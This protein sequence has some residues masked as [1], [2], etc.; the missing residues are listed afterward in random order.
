MK[1]ARKEASTKRNA[2]II[3][4]WPKAPNKPK[5]TNVNISDESIGVHIVGIKVDDK[6]AP[7]TDV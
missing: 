5:L 2:S 7:T 6:K 1:G 3:K 4:K